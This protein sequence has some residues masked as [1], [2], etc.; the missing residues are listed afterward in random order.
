M[1]S[2]NRTKVL[3]IEGS[4]TDTRLIRELLYD[5]T[6][7]R[8]HV[9]TAP[10]LAQGLE[11]LA[12]GDFDVILLDLDLPDSQGIAT[13]RA[14]HAHARHVPLIVL[15]VSCDEEEGQ[16]A[17]QEGAQLFLTKDVLASDASYGRIFTRTVRY[18]IEHNRAEKALKESERQ[19]RTL[20]ETAN[21]IIL[22]VDT[23]GTITFINEHGARFFGYTSDEL[24]GKHVMTIIPE[25][26]STGRELT[27]IIEDIVSKPHDSY[28][29]INE[30]ITK[31]GH[32]V[33]VNWVNRGL[34]N[35]EGRHV[36]DLAIGNDITEQRLAEDRVKD[37]ALRAEIVRDVIAAG[38][39]AADL[40]SALAAMVDIVV[41]RLRL[42]SGGILLRDTPHS[43]ALHYAR[44]YTKEQYKWAAHLPLTQPRVARVM[45]G[46]PVVSDD[47]Q[48]DISPNLKKMNEGVASMATVPLVA[49]YEVVGFYN[50]A[51]HER[52]RHFTEEEVSLL[53]TLGREAGTVIA[54][55]QAEE[56][57]Q[58]YAIQL[59]RYSERLEELVEERTAQLKNAERLAGIGETAAMIGHDLRN[60]LQGLQYIVDLQKLRFDRT[61]LEERDSTDWKKA[62]ENFD[63][64]SEQIFYMDKIVGDLQDYARPLQPQ[65]ETMSLNNLVDDVLEQV[66]RDGNVRVAT[67]VEGINI[68]ADRHL[69]QR[70]FSNIILNALQAMPEGGTLTI[71]G[72]VSDHASVVTFSDTGVG[73]PTEIREKLFSPLITGKAKGTGLGLAVVKRILD[74]HDG[75]IT[76]DSEEGNGTTF[77]VTL[78]LAEA[79]ADPAEAVSGSERE[80]S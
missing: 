73:I 36:G 70:A 8:F 55:M 44:G 52:L 7:E 40:N 10:T 15:T 37:H 22:T 39:K 51:T 34:I 28:V 78:P 47:Y 65:P 19:Y 4:P 50:V 58:R 38:N 54:R 24:I 72:T 14:V 1:S 46:K 45:A 77:T 27:P 59:K 64:I 42:D 74:A 32:R 16:K 17:V 31:D 29:S 60:P 11:A 66:P 63:R 57:A 80:M 76:F 35:G 5:A 53:T 48:A 41:D 9:A 69:M 26:E 68:N 33:W 49:R 20:V 25:I 71:N 79:G 62:E 21:N 30:N 18:A 75:T 2:E 6:L 13:F 3:L 61:P 43:V 67:F 23:T 12:Q 56:D